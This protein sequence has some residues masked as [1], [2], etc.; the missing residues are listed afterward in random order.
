MR[1]SITQEVA[2]AA[3]PHL[4]RNYALGVINGALYTLA[5]SLIDSA[6]VLTWFLSRL[7]APN[8]LI[9]LVVPLRDAGWFLPQLFVAR[10]QARQ[11]YKLPT[12]SVAALVRCMAWATMAVVVLTQREPDSVDYRLLCPVCGQQR[13]FWLGRLAVYGCGRQDHPGPAAWPVFCHAHV[14]RRGFGHCR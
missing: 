13:G 4:R 5:E 9:G 12:Y 1:V 3:D 7:S 14:S 10:H 6:L 8:V 2:P 11:P